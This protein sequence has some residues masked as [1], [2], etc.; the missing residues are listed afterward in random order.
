MPESK[1]RKDRKPPPAQRARPKKEIAK[2]PSPRWYAAVMFALM[3]TGVALVL[4]NYILS[5]IFSR[6]GLFAGL[7]FIGIGFVMTMSYK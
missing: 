4:L 7:G 6:W 5:D 2:N 1:H 3:G